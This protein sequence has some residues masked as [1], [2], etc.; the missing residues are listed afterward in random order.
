MSKLATLSIEDVR[1]LAPAAFSAIAHPRVSDRYSLFRT[2]DIVER[3]E[4]E[5]WLIT[6]ASQSAIHTPNQRDFSQ[7]LVALTRPE[8]Q[9][10]SEQVEI[11]MLNSND[12]RR[13]YHSELGVF[14]FACANGLVDASARFGEMDLRHFGYAAEQLND[15]TAKFVA[16]VPETVAVIDAWKTK[17]ISPLDSLELA[18]FALAQRY[19]EASPI[20]AVELL[21]ARRQ[22]DIGQDLWR[23]FNVIQE[24]LLK[25]GQLYQKQT[26]RGLRNMSIRPIRSIGTNLG[27]NKSLWRAAEALY[28]GEDLALPA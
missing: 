14:K 12:G 23:V 28:A 7:H 16:R 3:L 20:E 17:M 19:P 25:G 18:K 24:N 2:A 15:A 6:R 8:F 5:G 21:Y 22:D 27:I 1:S 4:R 26:K 10:Q 13:A 11:L 9:Y